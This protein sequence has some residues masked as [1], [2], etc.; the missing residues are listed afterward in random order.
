[1]I[2]KQITPNSSDIDGFPG[3]LTRSISSAKTRCPRSGCRVKT[4]AAV[5][6]A[7]VTAK[8]GDN[9]CRENH[10][11]AGFLLVVP[12]GQTAGWRGVFLRCSVV[13]TSTVIGRSMLR[14][15][16][17]AVAVEETSGVD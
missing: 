4:A 14:A 7:R 16:A 13:N 12:V 11:R 17:V 8:F 2:F 3:L 9:Q 1:V 6:D 10:I 15:A 5:G